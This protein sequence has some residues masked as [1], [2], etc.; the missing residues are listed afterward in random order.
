MGVGGGGGEGRGRNVEHTK[1]MLGMAGA[2]LRRCAGLGSG[3]ENQ[4]LVSCDKDQKDTCHL[5]SKI[6]TVT[7]SLT[8]NTTSSLKVPKNPISL[9]PQTQILGSELSLT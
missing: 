5:D 8:C 3:Y 6:S 1:G 4:D 7:S 9:Q 2:A